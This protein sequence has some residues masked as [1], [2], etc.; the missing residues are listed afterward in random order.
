MKQKKIAQLEKLENEMSN[1]IKNSSGNF[2]S[3]QLKQI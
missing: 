2:K 1:R 3:S